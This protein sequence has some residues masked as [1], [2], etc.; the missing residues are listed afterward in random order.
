MAQR[1]SLPQIEAFLGAIDKEDRARNRMALIVARAS[2][3]DADQFKKVMKE[4]G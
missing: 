1:Y 2:Q 4:I 3:C